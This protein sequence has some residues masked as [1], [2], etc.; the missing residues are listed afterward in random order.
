MAK[1]NTTV[2]KI[3]DEVTDIYEV[4]KSRNDLIVDNHQNPTIGVQVKTKQGSI[5]KW[6]NFV[7]LFNGDLSQLRA[8][9]CQGAIVVLR[10]AQSFLAFSLGMGRTQLC[11]DII[12][13]R[14]GLITSLNMLDEGKIKAVD[15]KSLERSGKGKRE[16]SSEWVTI[17]D[18]SIDINTEI[19]KSVTG[20]N[21][22]EG[23]GKTMTGSDGL[24][25]RIELDRQTIFETAGKLIKN[26]QSDSYKTSYGWINNV[27]I[28]KKANMIKQLN[29][30]LVIKINSSD[31]NIWMCVPDV[32]EWDKVD[33]FR[34]GS[35]N[36]F[37]DI[38]IDEW[39][40]D[41]S[42]YGPIELETLK[43]KKIRAYSDEG[44]TIYEWPVIKCIVG[45]VE[46]SGKPYVLNEGKWFCFEKKYSDELKRL[47][48]EIELSAEKE[49]NI[50]LKKYNH[51]GEGKYNEDNE[52]SGKF[53]LMDKK[54]I[55]GIELCDLYSINR[56]FLHIKRYG[57]SSCLSHLFNQGIVSAQ[58]WSSDKSFR[59]N[60][61]QKLK[62]PFLLLTPET[63]INPSDYA[64]KY[65]IISKRGHRFKLPKFS[66]IS[67]KN[68]KAVLERMGYRVNIVK[69]EDIS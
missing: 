16:Q 29:D 61:N 62:E 3:K 18:F 8:N 25:L 35:E 69:I 56:E 2:Y 65:G 10:V 5:P 59:A 12:E 40:A 9:A 32:I 21:S 51:E 41:V 24:N 68:I 28:V 4:F 55:D 11:Q 20:K 39:K 48:R 49:S 36:Q 67:Y 46:F 54:L 38:L 52:I 43:R 23:I 57:G 30:L 58:L 14:F 17:S 19:L 42:Q 64:V 34:Y 27:F 44:V 50:G 15:L 1:V 7:S 47:E 63:P 66:L 31:E 45:E 33:H 6:S 60:A 37:D 22:I 13:E 26:Y 53:F